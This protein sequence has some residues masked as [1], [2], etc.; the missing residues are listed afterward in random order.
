MIAAGVKLSRAGSII[1][2]ICAVHCAL[3]PV[4]LLALPFLAAHYGISSG[5]FGVVFSPATEWVF[6]GVII[7]V[8]GFGV[9]VTYP[10]HRDRR[11]AV[12]T[13]AGFIVLLFVRLC[14]ETGSTVEIAGDLIG[15]ASIACGGWI[16]RVLCRCHGCHET[17]STQEASGSAGKRDRA[18]QSSEAGA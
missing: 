9:L 8:A 1:S 14:L 2:L 15:A 3:T 16:N 4:A 10:V 7:I 5:A 6:L 11:P 17:P 13:V 12:L 18:F